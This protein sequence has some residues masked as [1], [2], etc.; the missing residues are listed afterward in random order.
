MGC[1]KL[2][3]DLANRLRVIDSAAC[4]C[5][6]PTEDASHYFLTCNLFTEQRQV[7][8]DSIN[9]LCQPTLDILLYGDQS[10][11]PARNNLIFEA[12]HVYLTSTERFE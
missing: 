7:L 10:L 5:G 9:N 6:H 3:G 8:F 11:P 2:N 1:S 4:S 12:V